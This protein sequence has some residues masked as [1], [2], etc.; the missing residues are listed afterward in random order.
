[1]KFL[2]ISMAS[3]SLL[4]AAHPGSRC[5]LEGVLLRLAVSPHCLWFSPRG[6]DR[7]SRFSLM[8]GHG[9]CLWDTIRRLQG[10][11]LAAPLE[12]YQTELLL[13]GCCAPGCHKGTSSLPHHDKWSLKPT[14]SSCAYM[15]SSPRMNSSVISAMNT[16]VIS[17]QHCTV[18]VTNIT[19]RMERV[20]PDAACRVQLHGWVSLG[21]SCCN[22]WP[23]NSHR[24]SCI[25]GHKT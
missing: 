12:P 21:Q 22:V 20:S 13:H 4:I 18:S 3:N 17:G 25:N 9:S 7:C 10:V 14:D 15:T 16:R 8:D 1:L 6:L 19:F 23:G 24:R 11:L 5:P 2:P